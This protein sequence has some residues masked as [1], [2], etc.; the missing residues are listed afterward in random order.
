MKILIISH[1]VCYP[2]QGGSTLRQFNLLKESSKHN[3]IYLLAFNQ[4]PI[5]RRPG[6]LGDS[7]D[8]LKRYCK[9]VKIIDVPV[10][11]SKLRWYFLLLLNLFSLTPYSTWRFRS[12]EMTDVIK[13]YLKTNSFDLIQTDTIALANY[14]KLAPDLPKV[15][16][17]ENI[18]SQLLRR[19]SR[20]HRNLP[21]KMY[22]AFQAYK[23]RRYERRVADMVDCN[24]TVSEEDKRTLLQICPN[25]KIKV[26]PNG[27][28]TDY[29]RPIHQLGNRYGLV[30]AGSMS[31]FPNK[32]GMIF[33][34]REIWPR[35]KGAVP[36]VTM[37]VIGSDPPQE[38]LE[39]AQNDKAFKVLGFVDDVRPH[40]DRAAVY[41]VPIRVGGGTRLKILDA[42]AMGKAIVSIAVGAEGLRVADGKDILIADDPN[43]FTQKVVELIGD[44]NLR[45][46]LGLRARKTVLDWYSWK[47]IGP[48]LQKVYACVPATSGVSYSSS[49]KV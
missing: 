45:E 7:K 46:E 21:A 1:K 22:L 36:E 13:R 43:M 31:W 16:V 29:F 6:R 17:H 39:L 41:V 14:S 32:D 18:E 10:D 48:Q 8:I 35:I 30:F 28:D 9:E 33:F 11:K 34:A 42:M 5:L 25:A 12:R 47:T 27:T 37:E 23:L 15:L 24:I 49:M 4:K 20:Y 26:V 19:R 44:P 2:P 3:E 40:I 38:V